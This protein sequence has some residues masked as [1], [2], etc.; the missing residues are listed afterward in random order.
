[1]TKLGQLPYTHKTFFDRKMAKSLFDP[2]GELLGDFSRIGS[3]VVLSSLPLH[4]S[5]IVDM[6][7]YPTRAEALLRFLYWYFF[8]DGRSS[9]HVRIN[10]VY[11]P[12]QTQSNESPPPPYQT[13]EYTLG[14]TVF[15][16]AI[17]KRNLYLG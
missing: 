10:L 12:S 11:L 6:M 5:Y 16:L 1:M 8:I 14:S 7:I 4:P 17:S 13:T 2:L 15:V 3:H 9:Y